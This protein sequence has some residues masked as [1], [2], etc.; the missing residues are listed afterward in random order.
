MSRMYG[1]IVN[2]LKKLGG[3]VDTGA[4]SRGAYTCVSK[5]LGIHKSTVMRIWRWFCTTKSVKAAPR[6]GGRQ[7]VTLK[8]DHH[9]YILFLVRET[10]SISLGDIKQKLNETC[11]IQVSKQTISAFL[12]KDRQTR[13]RLV[14]LAAERFTDRNLRYSQAFVDILHRTDPNRIK[15]FDKSGLKLPDVCNPRYGHSLIGERAIEVLRYTQTPNVTLNL[16]ISFTGIS[17]ANVI[18]G[19]SNTDT[20]TQFFFDALNLTT[21]QGDFCLKPGDMVI[22]DNCP[23]HRHRAENILAPFLDCLGIEYIFKPTYSP[24]LNAAELCFQHIK[25]LFKREDIRE[26]ALNNLQ[27]TIMNCVNS[28]STSDCKEYYKHIGY[29]NV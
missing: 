21:N 2:K 26:M 9:R 19:A 16:L 24:N 27:Y 22:V 1:V 13:K 12:Q 10:P 25:T 4:V 15:F 29:L 18:E 7:Y 28:I 6:C 17:Y 11:N 20:Y 14:R 5:Q 8:P 23:I 3:N